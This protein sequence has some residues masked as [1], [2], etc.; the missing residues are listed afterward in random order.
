MHYESGSSQSL[1]DLLIEDSYVESHLTAST[2][3]NSRLVS[4]VVCANS[5]AEAEAIL[6]SRKFDQSAS[7]WC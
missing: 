4:E 5:I 3:R 6:Q 7:T 1:Q 2:L